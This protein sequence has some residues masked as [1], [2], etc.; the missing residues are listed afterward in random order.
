MCTGGAVGNGTGV[1]LHL[2]GSDE[3]GSCWRDSVFLRHLPRYP[4]PVL[5]LSLS[6]RESVYTYVYIYVYTI[7][8]IHIGI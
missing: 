4:L 8:Y 7:M 1:G 6:Q 3:G 2:A 5:S